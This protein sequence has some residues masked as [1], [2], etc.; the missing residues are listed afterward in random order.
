[1][2][3]GKISKQELGK[4]DLSLKSDNIFNEKVLKNTSKE[5]LIKVGCPVWSV[6][7]WNGKIYPNNAKMPDL[8]KLYSKQFNT[9]ELN[10]T[11]YQIPSNETI[12]RWLDET[13]DGFTFCTKFPQIISHHKMLQNAEE[14]TYDFCRQ[15]LDLG[16][17][18][19]LP[20]L[21]LAPYFT[22][23]QL[24]ILEKYL[25]QLPDKLKIAVEFR[26]EDWFKNEF[27]WQETLAMMNQMGHATVITDVAGRRDVVHQSLSVSKAFIRWI[28]NEHPSDYQRIDEWVQ[29][30]KGWLERGL[31][32][33]WLFVHINENINSPEMATYWIQQLNDQCELKIK[34]PKFQPKV[35]QM[36]LF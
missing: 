1:M 3:F 13:T 18:L 10:V 16:H 15:I 19:G 30:I 25:N 31:Q 21:Q 17:K 11:H 20:F 22:P 9:I 26:H 27:I 14:L 28:G 35:E 4:T 5:P 29:R 33:L 32:E 8:L 24:P 23:K 7:E 2:D 12:S 34:A 36:T 6:K